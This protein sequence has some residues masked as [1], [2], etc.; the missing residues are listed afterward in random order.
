[1]FILSMSSAE[2]TPTPTERLVRGRGK[3]LSLSRSASFP[4]NPGL[5]PTHAFRE[6]DRRGHHRTCQ[7][8]SPGL[9]HTCNQR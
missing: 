7:G 1:M 6:N 3:K 4:W 9:I 5:P 2:T 8:P